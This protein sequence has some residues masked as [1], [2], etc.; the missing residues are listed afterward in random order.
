MSKLPLPSLHSGT[1]V[2]QVVLYSN[3]VVLVLSF[4]NIQVLSAVV[5][6]SICSKPEWQSY[7]RDEKKVY[8]TLEGLFSRSD[9]HIITFVL[10]P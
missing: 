4:I 6:P 1:P 5:F 2:L 8:F 9:D 7:L 10:L 3:E